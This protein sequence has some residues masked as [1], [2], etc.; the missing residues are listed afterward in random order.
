MANLKYTKTVSLF[1]KGAPVNKKYE[2][3]ALFPSLVFQE[4][5]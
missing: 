1:F 4:A 5:K 3:N 2:K